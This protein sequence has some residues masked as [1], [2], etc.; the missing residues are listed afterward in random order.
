MNK[1]LNAVLAILAATV[2]SVSANAAV[3]VDWA[4]LA[5]MPAEHQRLITW[6]GIQQ[7]ADVM[8]DRKA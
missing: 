6:S 1:Q 7:I 8:I 3:V 5:A 4:A 2:I